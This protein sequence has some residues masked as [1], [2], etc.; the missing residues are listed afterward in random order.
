MSLTKPT[1]Y[2]YVLRRLAAGKTTAI[3]WKIANALVKAG[4]VTFTFDPGGDG[5][6]TIPVTITDAGR[7]LVAEKSSVAEHIGVKSKLGRSPVRRRGR[8]VVR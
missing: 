3:N 1:R 5:V 8:R 4:L 7:A 2:G 6:S